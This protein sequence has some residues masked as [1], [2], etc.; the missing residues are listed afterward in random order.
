MDFPCN[1][2]QTVLSSTHSK[3]VQMFS[4][5]EIFKDKTSMEIFAKCSERLR[6]A[7]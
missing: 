1:M 5:A 4:G 3:G 6:Y 7:K 2:E